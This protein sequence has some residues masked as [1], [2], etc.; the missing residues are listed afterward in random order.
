M[1]VRQHVFCMFMHA[2]VFL[3]CVCACVCIEFSLSVS[4]RECVCVSPH[5]CVSPHVCVQSPRSCVCDWQLGSVCVCVCVCVREGDY[6]V[7]PA[8]DLCS[9]TQN[10]VRA[11]SHLLSPS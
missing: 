9:I 11:S 10:P 1:S 7:S 5:L 4:D 2:Y 8:Q 6:C 3:S